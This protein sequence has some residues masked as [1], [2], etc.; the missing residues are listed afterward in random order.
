MRLPRARRAF[1][2][3]DSGGRSTGRVRASPG[4][5]QSRSAARVVDGIRVLPIEDFLRALWRGELLAD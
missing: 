4:V 5:D 2:G 3:L 1:T